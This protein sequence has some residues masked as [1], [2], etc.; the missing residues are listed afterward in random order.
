MLLKKYHRNHIIFGNGDIILPLSGIEYAVSNEE[1]FLLIWSGDDIL[2]TIKNI[3]RTNPC[4]FEKSYYQTYII[5]SHS[6]KRKIMKLISLKFS[7]F[8]VY[9]EQLE[10]TN[11]TL[12]FSTNA[13]YIAR[14]LKSIIKFV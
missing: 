5:H 12:L 9:E 6:R 14:R 1:G 2:S 8:S 7:R 3:L 10:L 4:R 11:T 13:K